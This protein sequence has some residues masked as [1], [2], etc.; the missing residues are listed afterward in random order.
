VWNEKNFNGYVEQ[1]WFAG[2]HSNVG[3]GY[4]RTGLSD[5][6][7]Q[8]MLT[9]AEA[10]GLIFYKDHIT[11]IHDSANVYDK[12]YDSRDGIAI[13]YRYG[14]R[15]LA[16]LCENKLKG[17]IAI[18][19]S[20][21]KKIKE[22]SEG[23]APDGIP[24]NFDVVDVDT[25]NPAF[26]K[27]EVPVDV[28]KNQG[29]PEN[30]GKPIWGVLETEVNKIVLERKTLYR[31]LVELTMAIII[32]AGYFWLKPPKSVVEL[33]ACEIEHVQIM[34][35]QTPANV[36]SC[37]LKS[38]TDNSFLAYQQKQELLPESDDFK[39]CSSINEPDFCKKANDR[40]LKW[41]GDIL[42]YLTP[43]YFE[44]FITYVVEVYWWVLA[45]MLSILFGL[46]RLRKSYINKLDE[47]CRQ[48]ADLL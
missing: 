16:E 38:I 13:Y 20:A 11:A 29:K 32:V 8:W 2:V 34:Q 9:K 22:F 24:T 19:Y 7:L 23:Y 12:L 28:Q 41:L 3:G 14:P 45:G 6:A 40:P 1:V 31:V 27:I 10:H 4:P 33:N 35:I 43:S 44:N 37:G 21:Y 26:S 25:E 39:K 5:V 47:I 30:K 36:S 48:M 18:H 15:K 46:N 17:N 42:R